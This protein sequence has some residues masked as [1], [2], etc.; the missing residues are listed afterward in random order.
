MERSDLVKPD[1]DAKSKGTKR[2]TKKITKD[3]KIQLKS[4]T[5]KKIT[6][7][8]STKRVARGKVKLP[9]NHW[10]ASNRMDSATLKRWIRVMEEREGEYVQAN[11]RYLTEKASL[12][13][14]YRIVDDALYN[15]QRAAD[16]SSRKEADVKYQ[17]A[18]LALT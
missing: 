13:A 4:E 6:K 5:I 2:Q 3:S 12:D 11:A 17:E 7:E 1:V 9:P 14:K 18:F 15:I 10:L 16:D 8:Q